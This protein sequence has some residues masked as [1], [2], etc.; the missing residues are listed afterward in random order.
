MTTAC[1]EPR[2]L[3]LLR[4]CSGPL[5]FLLFP[6]MSAFEIVDPQSFA[7]NVN[8]GV[9]SLGLRD[10][11]GW[12]RGFGDPIGGVRG[13]HCWDPKA[14]PASKNMHRRNRPAFQ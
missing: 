1:G 3:P 9:S 5:D 12:K 8:G 13:T 7:F 10:Y 4:F 14:S 11:K 2:G 6:L